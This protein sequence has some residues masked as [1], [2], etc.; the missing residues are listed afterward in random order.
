MKISKPAREKLKTLEGFRGTAYLCPAGVW[1][2]GYGFT[3]GVRE[4]DT[5]TQTEANDRL[6][7]ELAWFENAVFVE[8]GGDVTQAQFDA[9]VLFCFNIGVEKFRGSSVLKAHNRGDHVA[10]ARAFGLWNKATVNGKLQVLAGLTRRRA[11]EA[12]MYLSDSVDDTPQVVAPEKPVATSTT[13]IA[14]S[15]AAIATATQ[16]ADAVGKL[17]GSVSVLGD[18]MMPAVA[19][20]ALVAIGWVLYER[21]QNRA[22][23]AI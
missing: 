3:E 15:T 21:Y 6:I 5:I 2:L 7:S 1:T 8:T 17:K 22:R 20:V 4:G 23:G 16:I 11:E 19:V 10:A 12:A 13:V 18:W 9:M 14:G